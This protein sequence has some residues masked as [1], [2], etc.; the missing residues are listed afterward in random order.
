[1]SSTTIHTEE[2][3]QKLIKLEVLSKIIYYKKCSLS[4]DNK[5]LDNIDKN[6]IDKISKEILVLEKYVYSVKNYVKEAIESCEHVNK[7]IDVKDNDVNNNNYHRS[8]LI[9]LYNRLDK[10]FV[11]LWEVYNDILKQ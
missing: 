9:K 4:E 10:S 1:M 11:T 8:S 5:W 7:P 3:E 6:E 2:V